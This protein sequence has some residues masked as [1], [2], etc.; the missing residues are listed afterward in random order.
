MAEQRMTKHVTVMVRTP[1]PDGSIVFEPE[2]SEDDPA[3][4]QES[5]LIEASMWDDLGQPSTITVTVE[6][7]DRLNDEPVT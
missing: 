7:G 2:S 4:W 1:T 3:L 6:P 5:L